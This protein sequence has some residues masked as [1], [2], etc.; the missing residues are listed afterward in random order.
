MISVRLMTSAESSTM[1]LQTKMIGHQKWIGKN[2]P[3]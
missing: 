3:F 1:I 2:N